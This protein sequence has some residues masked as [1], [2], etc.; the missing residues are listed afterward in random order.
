MKKIRILSLAVLPTLATSAILISC[1]KNK[2]H[3]IDI[4]EKDKQVEAEEGLDF[5]SYGV[6]LANKIDTSSQTLEANATTTG[7]STSGLSIAIS[8]ISVSPVD[9]S[10]IWFVAR[11]DGIPSNDKLWATF[12]ITITCK[13]MEGKEVWTETLKSFKLTVT[14]DPEP[15]V[16]THSVSS[17]SSVK[18]ITTSLDKTSFSSDNSVELTLNNTG[19]SFVNK[20]S[21]TYNVGSQTFSELIDNI[22]V[23]TKIFTLSKEIINQKL[24]AHSLSEMG[25]QDSVSVVAVIIG[26]YEVDANNHIYKYD[27]QGE[28]QQLTS[29]EFTALEG[30]YLIKNQLN[31]FDLATK[32]ISELIDSTTASTTYHLYLINGTYF[33]GNHSGRIGSSVI[34][35][36]EIQGILSYSNSRLAK[37]KACNDGTAKLDCPSILFSF[38]DLDIILEQRQGIVFYNNCLRCDSI[39]AQ[40]CDF[41]GTLTIGCACEFTD[42]NFDTSMVK[43]AGNTDSDY[44]IFYYAYSVANPTNFTNCYFKNCGKAFKAYVEGSGASHAD[45]IINFYNCKFELV[46]AVTDVKSPFNNND[47]CK[48]TTHYYCINYDN[49]T[50]FINYGQRDICKSSAGRTKLNGV[51]VPASN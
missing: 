7:T 45:D 3:F 28:L 26:S 21:L 27:A 31:M 34:I 43:D 50:T 9:D 25:K 6:P 24:A 10:Y 46:D 32:T 35:N 39:K 47:A 48:D 36:L 40:R 19:A 42:C 20:V 18:C 37:F 51:V 38:Y 30:K 13:N 2:S 16:E 14:H 29:S 15:T 49:K 1:H 8:H 12:D 22:G 44:C 23:G 5:A 4:P 17:K 41:D 11:M 33:P